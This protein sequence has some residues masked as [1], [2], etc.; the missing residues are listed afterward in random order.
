MSEYEFTLTF[1]LPDEQADPDAHV[2]ALYEAGCDDALIGTGQPGTIA[3]DFIR[4]AKSASAAINSAIKNVNAAIPG[5][6]LIE[7]KPDLVGL[8]DLAEILH[9][10][11]QNVRKYM[12][13]YLDFPKPVHTGTAMLWHLWDLARFEKFTVPQTVAELAKT[14][15]KINLDIQQH[16]YQEMIKE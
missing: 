13:N 4:E 7:V 10:S 16:R 1:S 3:L 12:I 5:S 6:D 2:D 11:R 15:F 8:S 9:C 14:T